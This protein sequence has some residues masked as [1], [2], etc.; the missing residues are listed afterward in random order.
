M[1][2]AAQIAWQRIPL[3]APHVKIQ[4]QHKLHGAGSP[5]NI[6]RRLP[7]AQRK[8]HSPAQHQAALAQHQVVLAPLKWHS[9][10][11]VVL[12]QHQAFDTVVASACRRS[13]TT[14]GRTAFF[15]PR[16]FFKS[17]ISLSRSSQDSVVGNL[18]IN[19]DRPLHRLQNFD[20]WQD[21]WKSLFP[22]RQELHTGTFV[23]YISNR[24]HGVEHM[25]S[26]TWR[27]THFESNTF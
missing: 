9:P 20:K 6:K 2:D 24:T 19:T 17:R 11:Q 8:W 21:I 10:A 5:H 7:A 27:R 15:R 25:A 12:A 18:L 22:F 23:E 1:Y 14:L 4:L 13:L 3:R 26:N 16:L